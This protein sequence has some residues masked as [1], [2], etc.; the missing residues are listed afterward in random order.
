MH[1]KPKPDQQ[2]QIPPPTGFALF[3]TVFPSIMLPMFLGVIDQTIVATALPAIA[4]DLGNVDLLSWVVVT[5]L[6]TATVAALVYGKLG[7]LFGR[8][9]LMFVALGVFLV[10]SVLCALAPTTT[11]LIIARGLQ[12]LG[13]GGLLSLSQ[14][15]IG[16]TI[17]P[18][19][20]ARYQGYLAAVG[21]SASSLGPVAGGFLT[22]QLGWQ[23]IFLIN[24]PL[25]ILAAL[26]TLRL[27]KRAGTGGPFRFDFPGLVLIAACVGSV[28]SLVELARQL[29]NIN[30]P[31]LAALLGLAIAAGVLLFM[32]ERRVQNPLVPLEL[33]RNP[34]IGR[35]DALAAMFGA[36][37]IALLTFLPIYY[38]VVFGASPAEIGLLLLP[39]TAGNGIGSM[40]T[41]QIVSRTG[42]TAIVPSVG[43]MVVVVLVG[44]LAFFSSELSRFQISALLGVNALFLGT[45]MGVV[46][47]TVQIAAGPAVLGSAAATV[48]FSRTLGSALGTAIVGVVLFGY[49]AATDQGA[50]SFFVKLLQDGGGDLEALSVAHPEVL[51]GE[52]M[53]AFRAAFAT[54]ACFAT[55]ACALAWSLP[56]RRLQ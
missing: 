7:D 45:V 5:Y 3:L 42:R 20:R 47:L 43:L 46:Q 33:I 35:A 37:L 29:D 13:G 25:C 41:G 15:L 26:L 32:Q 44:V 11:L 48:Q 23:S 1:F 14:A 55:M 36:T 28:L 31:V 27:P 4:G 52:L 10:A 12:G 19:D 39:M 49:L 38:R 54:I 30:V 8:R 50:M 17:P 2:V 16:E 22:Q 51:R 18:R 24:I 34:A 56:T 21:V 40:L 53:G 9:R 6:V